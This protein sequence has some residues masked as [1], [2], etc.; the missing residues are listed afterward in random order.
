[1]KIEVVEVLENK[2]EIKNY[3]SHK[4]PL[5]SKVSQFNE[6]ID[7]LY[8]EYVEQKLLSYEVFVKKEGGSLF[9]K[10]IQ[11]ENLSILVNPRNGLSQSIE[12]TNPKKLFVTKD[13][14]IK[15]E[16]D[17]E[18]LVSSVDK[19]LNSFFRRKDNNIDKINLVNVRSIY[20]PV[21]IFKYRKRKII[22][23]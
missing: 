15:S 1:M 17:E 18:K 2:N 12:I 23:D 10:N 11:K 3:I 16:I 14:I 21:W 4:L 19:E 7:S 22:L 5:F 8:V 13:N 6:D 9:R 20:K